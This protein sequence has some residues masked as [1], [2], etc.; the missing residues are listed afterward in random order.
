MEDKHNSLNPYQPHIDWRA[1]GISALGGG[2]FSLLISL[3][4]SAVILNEPGFILR[5]TASQILGPEIIPVTEGNPFQVYLV[6]L[7]VHLVISAVYAILVVLVIHRWGLIVGLIGGMLIGLA[8]YT[9]TIYAVSY[10]IPWIYTLRSWIS[11][12]SSISLGGSIG[13]IYELF[14]S[15][16]LPFPQTKIVEAQ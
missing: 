4:L 11:L 8:I 13:F 7:L 12:V 15:Y 6:G 16:D 1:F 14:D 5:L 3:L 10:F 2:V 9:I